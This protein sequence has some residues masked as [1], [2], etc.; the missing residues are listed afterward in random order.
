[1]YDDDHLKRLRRNY[2]ENCQP[3]VL[4]RLKRDGEL[5]PHLQ[6]IA[7]ACRREQ[8]RLVESGRTWDGQAWQ[9]AIRTQILELPED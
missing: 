2:L 9:W 4:A 5:E 6:G 7:D 8:S 1:M 3:D